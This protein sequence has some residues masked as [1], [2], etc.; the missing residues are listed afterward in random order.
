MSDR[1]TRGANRLPR[2]AE[3]IER[4]A[5]DRARRF[6]RLYEGHLECARDFV[7]LQ[8]P[9]HADLMLACWCHDL[10]SPEEREL[11][12]KRREAGTR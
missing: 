10:L 7:R 2:K 4:L 1:G 12:R 3:L 9:T 6:P 11:D 8:Y 5:S